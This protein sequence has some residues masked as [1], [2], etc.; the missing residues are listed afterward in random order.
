MVQIRKMLKVAPI[1]LPPIVR[2]RLE[3]QDVYLDNDDI[4]DRQQIEHRLKNYRMYSNQVSTSMADING[5]DQ[6]ML[7]FIKASKLS[8]HL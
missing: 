6:I 8:L 5:K 3:S 2:K 4:I 7:P 1:E